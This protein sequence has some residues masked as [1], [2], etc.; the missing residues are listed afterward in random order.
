MILYSGNWGVAR[1]EDTFIEAYT[2]Y[3]PGS[4]NPLRLWINATGA[5]ADRVERELRVRGLPFYRSH[6]V[7]LEQLASLLIAVGVHLVTLRDAFVGYVLPS[8]IHACL[9]SGKR[10][11][12]IGGQA[13]DV[14]RLARDSLAGGRYRRGDVEGASAALKYL[15]RGVA[16]DREGYLVDR[17]AGVTEGRS[18][19]P[20]AAT[21]NAIR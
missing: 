21:V 7:P 16:R 14:H 13:S 4:S 2:R 15:E 3:V 12:F 11:L 17:Q 18:S 9:E 19:R 6:L 10:I 5:K 8:K 1:D 20:G